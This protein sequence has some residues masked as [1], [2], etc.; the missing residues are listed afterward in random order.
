M[1][2]NVIKLVYDEIHVIS[3]WKYY[4]FHSKTDSVQKSMVLLLCKLLSVYALIL[5]LTLLLALI[6]RKRKFTSTNW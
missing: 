4:R 2:E 5:L 1:Q 6:T 3:A